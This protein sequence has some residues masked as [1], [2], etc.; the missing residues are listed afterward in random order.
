MRHRTS[1]KA[2][3]AIA[4]FTACA[5]PAGEPATG[6]A[7]DEAALRALGDAYATAWNARDAA[8]IAAMI[9]SEY[10]EITPDGRHLTSAADAQANLTAELGQ[11]PAGVT[12]TLTTEFTRFIGA[13]HAYSGGTWTTSGMP[14]GMPTR[15]SW[16]VV[17]VK[18]STGWK[19][20]SGLGSTDITPLM[21]APDSM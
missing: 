15:G 12:M 11:M 9:G 5:A 20:L 16:L 8:A 1:F 21:A 13:N 14:P 4:L 17:N 2:L 3:L 19:M 18:D 10:H 7:E 6:T